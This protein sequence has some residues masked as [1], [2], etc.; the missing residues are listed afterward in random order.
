MGQLFALFGLILGVV[1]MLMIENKAEE[2]RNRPMVK[3]APQVQPENSP[4]AI[5]PKPIKKSKQNRGI[6]GVINALAT[7]MA[8]ISPTWFYVVW[9]L[10]CWGFYFI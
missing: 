1:I 2:I 3:S 9:F 5:E 4:I 6:P 8:K 7:A 10:S